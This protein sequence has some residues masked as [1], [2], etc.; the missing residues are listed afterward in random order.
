MKIIPVLEHSV[1]AAAQL[2]HDYL[3][4]YGRPANLPLAK[5][6]LTTRIRRLESKVFVAYLNEEP[7]GF[8]QLYPSFSSL[9]LR[10]V[11]ILNDLYVDSRVR[12]Q[13]VGKALL[14]RAKAF[15]CETGAAHLALQT[16]V[17]NHAAAS[18]YHAMGWKRDDEFITFTLD[19]SRDN[20]SADSTS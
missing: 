1:D 9:S 18:L 19:L 2:F 15:G 7:V 16:A 13:G 17:T 14:M 8:M 5:E 11:W 20:V 4:F 10:S 12:K 3:K 6:F